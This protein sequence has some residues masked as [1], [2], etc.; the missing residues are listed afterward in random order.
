MLDDAIQQARVDWNNESVY[1]YTVRTLGVGPTLDLDLGFYFKFI[2]EKI[3]YNSV[4]YAKDYR[5][6]IV[7]LTSINGTPEWAPINI[8]LDRKKSIYICFQENETVDIGKISRPT[9]KAIE[10]IVNRMGYSKDVKVIK[11]EDVFLIAGVVG[12]KQFLVNLVDVKSNR[13]MAKYS[14]SVRELNEAGYRR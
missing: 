8:L 5:S 6:E 4:S 13:W 3:I 1:S 7:R 11:A 12:K 10:Y 2:N 14:Y 9:R